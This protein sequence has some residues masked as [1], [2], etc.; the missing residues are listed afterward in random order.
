MSRHGA[1]SAQ[2]PMFPPRGRGLRARL[3]RWLRVLLVALTVAGLTPL[4][5][6]VDLLLA[7]THTRQ[8]AAVASDGGC[9][10]GC[11]ADCD[12]G[13]QDAGC[14]GD[15]HHCGCCA[16][17]PRV[18]APAAWTPPGP[19]GTRDRHRPLAL[20]GPPDRAPPP[21]WQPPRA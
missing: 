8:V 21:P 2:T 6:A 5:Q 13:C 17:M 9:D 11:G 4:G 20:L 18:E 7:D 12:D 10:D 19:G 1:R 14:H 15:L 3:W 16:P